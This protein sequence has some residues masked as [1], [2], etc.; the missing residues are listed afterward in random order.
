MENKVFNKIFIVMLI[1]FM[2]GFILY[3]RYEYLKYND[4]DL[5]LARLLILMYFI[6][7]LIVIKIICDRFIN[8]KGDDKE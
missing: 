7:S 2:Q 1:L 4:R 6:F 8:Y 5:I 3:F